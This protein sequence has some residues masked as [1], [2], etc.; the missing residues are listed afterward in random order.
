MRMQL[1]TAF[2]CAL[3]VALL[4]FSAWGADLI[5]NWNGSV[6]EWSGTQ[7]NFQGGT[8]TNAADYVK[9]YGYRPITGSLW[10]TKEPTI[11]T[12][13][14]WNAAQIWAT[15][16]LANDSTGTLDVS[17]WLGNAQANF[18]VVRWTFSDDSSANLG[19]FTITWDTKLNTN[20][21]WHTAYTLINGDSI[22]EATYNDT[23]YFSDPDNRAP[24]SRIFVNGTTGNMND[25]KL[26]V[27]LELFRN[28]T[29]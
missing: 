15:D 11:A 5:G 1:K 17:E 14:F 28:P 25:G 16:T 6:L 19:A 2:W 18:A 23:I 22:S 7:K 9:F 21:S 20:D 13:Q 3:M 4:T 12:L 10:G 27:W 29:Q 26:S 8:A 24:L